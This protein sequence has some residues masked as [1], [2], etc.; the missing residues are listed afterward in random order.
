[1]I[2]QNTVEMMKYAASASAAAHRTACV[3]KGT[4]NIYIYI[5]SDKV[6]QSAKLKMIYS[7]VFEMNET[8]AGGCTGYI[9]V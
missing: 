9:I 4:T 2:T 5:H 8:N 3:S 7:T 6:M 1:M